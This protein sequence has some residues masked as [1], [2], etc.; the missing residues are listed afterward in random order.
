MAV[1]TLVD[2]AP[3]AIAAAERAHHTSAEFA[4][5]HACKPREAPTV[6]ERR[7]TGVMHTMRFFV[8]STEVES[9]LCVY[10][11]VPHTQDQAEPN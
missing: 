10:P 2:T 11:Y 8:N 5:L 3:L 7:G 4:W 6:A 1:D 9:R